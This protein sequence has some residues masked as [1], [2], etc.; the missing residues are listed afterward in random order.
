MIY[1]FMF[2]ILY[3]NLLKIN[4][5]FEYPR[6]ILLDKS[7]SSIFSIEFFQNCHKRF[8]KIVFLIILL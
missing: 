8:G 7:V 1:F 3:Y 5:I 2:N 4:K 6:D